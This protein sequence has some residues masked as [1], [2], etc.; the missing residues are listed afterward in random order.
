MPDRFETR[1]VPRS[2]GKGNVEIMARGGRVQTFKGKAKEGHKSDFTSNLVKSIDHF[3]V[4]IDKPYSEGGYRSSRAPKSFSQ[5]MATNKAM[6]SNPIKIFD[7]QTRAGDKVPIARFCILP[8]DVRKQCKISFRMKTIQEGKKS[9][10]VDTE[11]D[12]LFV[13]ADPKDEGYE[14]GTDDGA[15]EGAQEQQKH[16]PNQ[17]QLSAP[18]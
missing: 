8:S 2:D 15:D 7:R 1:W 14:E 11:P 17:L 5:L 9:N 6:C 18:L 10:E 3:V 4:N 12:T 13:T 16:D